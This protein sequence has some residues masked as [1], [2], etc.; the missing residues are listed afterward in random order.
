MSFLRNLTFFAAGLTALLALAIPSVSVAEDKKKLYKALDRLGTVIERI[1]ENFVEDVDWNKAIEA[2]INGMLRRLDPH[3]N[4]LPPRDFRDMQVQTRGAVGGLGLELTME[5]GVVKVVRPID[6]AP[7]QEAGILPGDLITHLDGE[8]IVGLTLGQAVEK[9][10]GPINTPI[11]VTIVRKGRSAPINIEVKRDVIRINPAKSRLIDGVG[12]VRIT[13]L[14]E[15]SRSK[16]VAAIEKLKKASGKKKIGLILDLRNNPGGLLDQA[17]AVADDFLNEGVIVVTQGRSADDKKIAKAKPGDVLN[18]GNLIVLINGGTAS[19]SEII[20]TA[21]QDNKRATVVGTRSF[22]MGTVQ[23]ILPLGALGALRLTT[24]QYLTPN[25]MSIQSKGVEP[26][27]L[28]KQIIP[29]ELDSK[30]QSAP[31]F[32]PKEPEKDTQLQQAL[33][34]LAKLDSSPHSSSA[35]TRQGAASGATQGSAPATAPASEI[36]LEVELEFWNSVKQSNDPGLL[37]LYLDQYP[38]GTFSELAKALIA[39]HGGER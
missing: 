27:V 23:T 25:K 13:T 14:N 34:L 2:G 30:H 22:G 17:I 20:A 19:G 24:A 7:A 28:V 32:V 26:D 36:D 9:M 12:Y 3:S 5:S 31:T 35:N 37:K 16:L 38:N 4:Y 6:E 18:G 29:A 15:I 8:Q 10:R 11:D 21:L 39:R 1:D 33:K